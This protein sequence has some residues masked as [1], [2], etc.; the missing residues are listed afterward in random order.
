MPKTIIIT[1]A[2]S[3]IGKALAHCLAKAG[4]TVIA[5]GRNKASLDELTL[6][7]PENIRAVVADITKGEDRIKIKDALLPDERGIYLVH[8]AGIAIPTVL[9]ELTEEEWD[10]HYLVN[11]KAPVFLTKLLLPHLQ[12]GGRILNISTGL[13]HNAL[14]GFSAYGVS[15]AALYLMK[16][17]LNTELHDQ[18]IACGSA[19]PGIVDTPIQE[20][21]RST[22][23][24]RFPAVGLFQGFKQRDELLA[25]ETAAKFL[26]WLLMDTDKEQFIK[27]DWDIYDTSHQPHW[28]NSSEVK[29]RSNK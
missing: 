4:H 6:S 19:M 29:K 22:S 11:T 18:D 20:H 8:N 5:V 7:A 27:G 24:T 13:A 26:A 28:A 21:I 25:P 16:E 12:N 23:I 14:P 9:T 15:K 1:G 2:S 17:Y 3:G 10:Q